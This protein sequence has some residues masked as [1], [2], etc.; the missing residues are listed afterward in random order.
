SPPDFVEYFLD[1]VSKVNKDSPG[2]QPDEM[3]NMSKINTE[4]LNSGFVKKIEEVVTN[5]F[6]DL[7]PK[8]INASKMSGVTFAEFLESAYEATIYYAAQ[9]AYESCLELY[10]VMMDQMNFKGFPISWDEFENVIISHLK[11]RLTISFNKLLEVLTK[12]KNSDA[13]REYHKEYAHEIWK[14]H[15]S[16]GLKPENLFDTVKFKEAIALF[17]KAY[18]SIVIPGQEAIQELTE[19]KANQYENEIKFLNTYGVL[20]E[21]RAN[22]MLARQEAEKKYYKLLQEEEQLK[23]EI[24]NVKFENE[25]IQ[26]QFEEKVKNMEECL[27]NQEQQSRQAV[28]QLKNNNERILYEQRM[29]NQR[30]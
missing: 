2:I 22:E 19:F 6:K 23:T 12:L 1:R 28:G 10:N 13:M 7:H 20:R 15:V 24:N 3:R 9:Q 18:E 21:E 29:Q 4:Q 26:N 8:Y 27:R 30:K 25:K 17:E 5:I 16:P 14:E 11:K